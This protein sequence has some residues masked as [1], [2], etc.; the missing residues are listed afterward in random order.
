MFF[1]T[2]ISVSMYN[3]IVYHVHASYEI[4]QLNNATSFKKVHNCWDYCID[5]LSPSQFFHQKLSSVTYQP[6]R[7]CMIPS[8]PFVG[9]LYVTLLFFWHAIWKPSRLSINH[10]ICQIK[11]SPPGTIYFVFG[12][13]GWPYEGY[14]FID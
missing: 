13:V 3:C 2:Q 11:D 14:V 10:L 4:W 9:V 6:S 8:S 1:I 5:I 7:H 12:G